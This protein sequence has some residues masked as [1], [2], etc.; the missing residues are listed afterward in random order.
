MNRQSDKEMLDLLD[1]KGLSEHLLDIFDAFSFTA[2][3]KYIFI[4]NIQEDYTLWSREAV[5]YFGLPS[6]IIKGAGEYLVQHIFPEDRDLYRKSLTDMLESNMDVYDMHYRVLNKSG[7]YVSCTCKGIVIRDDDLHPRYFA[8]TLVNHEQENAMDPATGL[9]THA[10]LIHK[11]EHMRQDNKP[12]CI[13]FAGVR[14]FAHINTT[15]GYNM[16]NKVLKHIADDFLSM[17]GNGDVFRLEGAKYAFLSETGNDS[18]DQCRDM[19]EK[20]RKH[21]QNET[22]ID[23]INIS[24]AL[25]GC[26]MEITDPSIDVNTVYNS[27]IYA[28]DKSKNEGRL[29]LVVVD[30]D[31]FQ[32]NKEYIELHTDIR[33]SI[34]NGCKGFFLTYQP[35]VDARTEEVAGAE[36]LLRFKDSKGNIVPPL[37]FI[38]WLEVDP[39]FYDLG[40]WIIRTALTDMLPVIE[41]N[42][43]FII[44][45]NLAY[46]QLQRSDFNSDLANIIKETGFPPVNIKLELTE[47]CRVLDIDYLRSCVAFFNSIGINTALDDFGTGYSALNLMADL[48]IMQIKIDK[49]F[50]DDIESNSARQSL[51]KAITQC[52]NELDK[53]VCVEGI[54]TDVLASYL[55]NNYNV[56]NFQGYHYA[57][58]LLIDDF[59]EYCHV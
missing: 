50:V 31:F 22:V 45:I 5:D 24:L 12:Y 7:E 43:N 28:L 10:A 16:G 38:D 1:S 47:R 30:A 18:F 36:A 58:P 34:K 2:S 14:K 39:L 54:E 4:N 37:K 19:F 49:S 53:A 6:I 59:L 13:F 29:D 9:P 51:L 8:G 52:A 48:P 35:I 3:G 21:L 25:C 32:G 41:K 27:V 55:R 40:N 17:K 33:E 56:T 15:Y 11:M 57:K 20:L 23:G 42:P 46:P 44:N 26:C